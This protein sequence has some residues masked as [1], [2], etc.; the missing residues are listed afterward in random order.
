MNVLASKLGLLD[1]DIKQEEKLFRLC[2][3]LKSKIL[4][5]IEG[6]FAWRYTEA[7]GTVL[8]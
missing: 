8:G 3:D 7:D 4:T 1:D 2:A 5:P 6:E